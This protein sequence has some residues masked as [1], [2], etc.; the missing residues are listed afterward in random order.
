MDY[1]IQ[2]LTELGVVVKIAISTEEA[3]GFLK[4]EKF[5]LVVSD[6]ARWNISDD[7]LRLIKRMREA[8]LYRP[9]ILTVG[10]HDPDRGTPAFSF[11]I[12]NR[13]D[14]LLNLVFD[15]VE[16]AKG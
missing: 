13:L 1:V 16:R 10:N 14:E 6:M 2:L 11:G 9:T 5:D 15:V 4:N 7:G 3:L 8:G 12:T